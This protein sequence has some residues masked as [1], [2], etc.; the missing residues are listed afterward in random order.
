MIILPTKYGQ[1]GNRL[2]YLRAYLAFALEYDVTLLNLAFVEYSRYFTCS[3]HSMITLPQVLS[4]PLRYLLM[5]CLR[6]TADRETLFRLPVVTPNHQGTIDFTDPAIVTACAETHVIISDGWPIINFS[7]LKKYDDQV[8]R[9]FTPVDKILAEVS[10]FI[11][12]ARTGCELLIGI[13][14]RQGDYL[15]W[16]NGRYFFHTDEYVDIM[17]KL[18]QIHDKRRVRFV[19]ASNEQQNWDLFAGFDYIQAPGSTVVDMY[20]LAECDEIYGPQ[21]SFSGWAS[22]YGN[23]PLC[24]ITTP[25]SFERAVKAMD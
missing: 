18:Q 22:F 19:V 12:Q 17:A 23:V 21:S 8:K 10:R 2:A 16:N 1:L 13:H 5:L 6:L 24:W 11:Q 15:T 20:V 7:L 3:S 25:K 9:I 4:A 14:I